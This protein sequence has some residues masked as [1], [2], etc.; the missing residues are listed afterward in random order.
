MRPWATRLVIQSSKSE[1]PTN[2]NSWKERG[3]WTV[4]RE[5]EFLLYYSLQLCD[6]GSV[7]GFFDFPHV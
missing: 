5:L 2:D 4:K 1:Q 6:L 7:T 3:I